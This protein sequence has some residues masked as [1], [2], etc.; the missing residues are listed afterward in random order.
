MDCIMIF[1]A[2]STIMPFTTWMSLD[3]TISD[4]KSTHRQSQR[5]GNVGVEV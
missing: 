4:H 5:T 2:V 3:H 1:P